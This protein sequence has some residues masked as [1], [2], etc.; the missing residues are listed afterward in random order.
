[1]LNF[2]KDK[3]KKNGNA[4]YDEYTLTSNDTVASS[5]ECTGLIPAL[6]VSDD[7]LQ[8]YSEIYNIPEQGDKTDIEA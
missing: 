5:T 6:P 4:G 8:S 7:D 2:D 3:R 1:M